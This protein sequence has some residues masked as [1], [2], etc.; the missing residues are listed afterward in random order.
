MSH[1]PGSVLKRLVALPRDPAGCWQWLGR[2][3]DKGVPIKQFNGKPIAARR[4]LWEQLFGLVP[5][6]LIVFNTCGDLDCVSPH[7]MRCGFD[8]DKNRQNLATLTI[9]DVEE[10]KRHRYAGPFTQY[11]LAQKFNVPEATLRDIWR[12]DRWGN[13]R[14]RKHRAPC[15]EPDPVRH[16]AASSGDASTEL[17]SVE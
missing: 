16:R 6:G 13:K 9:G 10:I 7:H 1:A 14:K 3:N 11:A 8:A 12:G 17:P 15:T 4:W 2:V 5:P